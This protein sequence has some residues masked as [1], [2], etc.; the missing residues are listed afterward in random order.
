MES[1]GS[2]LRGLVQT[3]ERKVNEVDFETQFGG[4]YQNRRVL[5]TGDT[6]FKGSWLTN[7]LVKLG[8][9]V[10]GYALAPE[11]S[12]NHFDLLALNYERKTADIRDVVALA[13]FVDA[14]KPEVV[15]HLAAQP[16]VRRSYKAPLETFETNVM[17]TANVYETCRNTKSV[18]AIVSVTTDK[19]YADAGWPWGYREND[20]LGGRD[21]YSC[22][23]ACVEL[24][25]SC[26]RQSFWN[27]R[28]LCATCRAGNVIGGGDWSEDR[29]IPDAIRAIADET[30]LEIRSPNAVRPWQHVLEPLASYL[31][32]GQKLLERQHI[33]ADSWNFGP[34]VSDCRTVKEVIQSLAASWPELNVNF[35]NADGQPHETLELRLDPSKSRQQLKIESIW[36][37]QEAVKRTAEWYRTQHETGEAITTEQLL[38]Y[39][40]EG[41]QQRAPWLDEAKSEI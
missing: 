37:W 9:I 40:R 2:S 5:V 17:G 25:T 41:E 20:T 8:A 3:L 36:T 32:V 30:T 14:T 1:L 11:S 35:G 22:S 34:P 16:L 18:E 6:G 13:N 31:H 4:I 10:S 26:Y 29:L 7:W 27:D 15:F 33:F 24:L 21:P 19:V 38:S 28:L 39:V 23:K 12:R